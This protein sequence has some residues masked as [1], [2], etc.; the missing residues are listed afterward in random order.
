[1]ARELD[2][3]IRWRGKPDLIVSDHGT[4]FSSNAPAWA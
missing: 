2:A 3:I 1:V 4:E